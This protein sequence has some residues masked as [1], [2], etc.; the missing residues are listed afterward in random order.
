MPDFERE[1]TFGTFLFPKSSEART[2][3][4]RPRWPRTSAM[5]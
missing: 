5:T 3:Y 2:Y 1:L 4:G